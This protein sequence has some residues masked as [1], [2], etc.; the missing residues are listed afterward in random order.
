[1]C[2]FLPVGRLTHGAG[3]LLSPGQPDFGTSLILVK[4]I[5]SN[6][7]Y[8]DLEDTDSLLGLFCEEIS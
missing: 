6:T 1:M 7:L 8:D 2:P 4:E 3:E 5:F